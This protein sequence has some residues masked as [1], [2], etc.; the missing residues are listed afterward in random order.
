MVRPQKISDAEIL[1]ATRAV[2]VEHGPGA[3][4]SLIAGRLDVSAPAIL[5]RMGSRD[6]LVARALCPEG[7]P[8][9]MQTLAEPVRPEALP[10]ALLEAALEAMAF[11]ARVVPLL[12][13]GRTANVDLSRVAGQPQPPGQQARAAFVRFIEQSRGSP[14]KTD[15]EIAA[16]VEA[17]LGAIEARCFSLY[18]TER[19]MSA[20][21]R[22]A[23]LESLMAGLWPRLFR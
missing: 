21:Q 6:E 1:A 10:E 20:K 11:F 5:K 13:V 2:L 4:L 7:P 18:L 22:R 17:L 9:F 12:V 3:P 15:P 8:A 14:R 19:K 23:W 16:F